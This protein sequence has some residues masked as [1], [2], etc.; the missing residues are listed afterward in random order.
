[1]FAILPFL[2]ALGILVTSSG[3]CLTNLRSFMSDET[4]RMDAYVV[5]SERVAFAVDETCKGT[6]QGVPIETEARGVTAQ[7]STCGCFP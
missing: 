5:V 6:S 3:H 1:M 2:L 4:P 7:R